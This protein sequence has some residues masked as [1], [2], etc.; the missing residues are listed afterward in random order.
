MLADPIPVPVMDLELVRAMDPDVIRRVWL[1]SRTHF[2]PD[3]TEELWL[4]RAALRTSLD[5]GP[6]VEH[7]IWILVPK[8]RGN[9]PS[10]ILS[11]VH[12]YDRAGLM[13][14]KCSEVRDVADQQSIN[15]SGQTDVQLKDIRIAYVL[16]VFTPTEHRRRGYAKTML[17]MLKDQLERQT[18]P[19]L[20]LSFLYSSVGANFYESSGW[21]A[22][23]SR[24]LVIEVPGH[25]FPE[26]PSG[27]VNNIYEIEDITEVNIQEIMDKDVE[28]L[29]SDMEQRA[30]AA[31][32]Q[33]LR[34]AA[35]IPE[36]RIFRGQLAIAQFTNSKVVK[37]DRLITRMGLRL[38]NADTPDNN[39]EH[40]F[41][42]WTY[43]VP[44]K[45]LLI[46][47]TRYQTVYQLQRLLTEAL[48]DAR[49]WDLAKV[50]M[51]DL[52]DED[53]IMASGIPNRDRAVGWSCLGQLR[54][55]AAPVELLLNEAFIWGL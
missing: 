11:A 44:H 5:L 16:L 21:P 3:M 26:L 33:N 47:R 54:P 28:L 25:V 29:R 22:I 14:E 52:K 31:A 39:G 49:E 50:E 51:W 45:L 37:A 35:I 15:G 17:G 12:S 46:L 2:G 48:K 10:A 30:L 8:G 32:P 4:E 9:D 24:E 7:K 6:G 55:R 36:A 20:E 13:S 1:N 23:R 18:D 34:F 42:I 27:S 40:A 41:I 38:L 19:P 43:L 53:A